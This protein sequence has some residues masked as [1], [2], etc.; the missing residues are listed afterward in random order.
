[1]LTS[2]SKLRRWR[3]FVTKS[4]TA[5]VTLVLS[6]AHHRLRGVR[7]LLVQLTNVVMELDIASLEI[8]DH[9]CIG[10]SVI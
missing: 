10:V 4:P 7:T 9:F 1:M 8:L 6:N 5:P 2:V 3:D